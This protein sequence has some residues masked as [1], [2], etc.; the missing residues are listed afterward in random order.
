[1]T[2]GGAFQ[3][4]SKKGD[5]LQLYLQWK[6]PDFLGSGFFPNINRDSNVS[7]AAETPQIVHSLVEKPPQI[8]RLGSGSINRPIRSISQGDSNTSPK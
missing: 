7:R 5:D 6:N 1:M 4:G 2:I 3:S 8:T